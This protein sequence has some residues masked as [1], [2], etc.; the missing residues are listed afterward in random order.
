MRAVGY[1]GRREPVGHAVRPHPRDAYKRVFDLA[2]LCAGLAALAP[3][4]VPLAA[5]VA[6]AVRCCDGGPVLYRQRRLGRDG[7]PFEMVK[8]RTM[9]VGADAVEGPVA[10]AR[11][12]AQATVVGRV[13][14]R[15]RLDELPQAVNVMRG[16]MSLVG[17][18]PE[19]PELAA[20]YE[21]EVT[22]FGRRLAVLP[23]I[24]G[25][26][27]ARRGAEATAPQKL[28]YDLLYIESMGPWLDLKLC[29]ACLA[30]VV[31]DFPAGRRGEPRGGR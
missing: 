7:R 22:G 10:S 19:R 13:L 31:R 16:E 4:W 21:R 26:A 8:F 29:A 6:T 28:R 3:L 17:P 18:R 27:Q 2:V 1:P 14:R 12:D 25:L 15:L 24:A 9:P 5:A 30:R 11:C 23:G 20:R